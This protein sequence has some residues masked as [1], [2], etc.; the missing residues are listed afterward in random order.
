MPDLIDD[1]TWREAALAIWRAGRL[2][3]HLNKPQ[4][5]GVP[6]TEY[7]PTPEDDEL[8]DTIRQ[9][10]YRLKDAREG[11]AEYKMIVRQLRGLR[12][13]SE[14]G[15]LIFEEFSMSGAGFID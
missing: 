4:S 9:L 10:F 3:R 11:S 1:G 14:V 15:R 12:E 2:F 5:K 13:G 8:E 7:V 6:M